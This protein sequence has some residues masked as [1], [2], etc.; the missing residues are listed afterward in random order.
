MHLINVLANQ[1]ISIISIDSFL[2][3]STF[4]LYAFAAMN[5]TIYLRVDVFL[6]VN[7]IF[8]SIAFVNGSDWLSVS[9]SLLSLFLQFL[10][11]EAL[12]Q[13]EY[14]SD[15]EFSMELASFSVRLDKCIVLSIVSWKFYFRSVFS[16]VSSSYF[17]LRSL[18]LTLWHFARKIQSRIITKITMMIIKTTAIIAIGFTFAAADVDIYLFPS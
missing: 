12:A 10:L 11:T 2:A 14:S 15:T 13:H 17:S 1:F 18:L 4:P 8:Y 16:L 5:S 3:T 7:F 6:Y 9:K